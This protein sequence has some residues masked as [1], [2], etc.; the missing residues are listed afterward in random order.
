LDAVYPRNLE[1]FARCFTVL[2]I[3]ADPEYKR[4]PE[5]EQ[6]LAVLQSPA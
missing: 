4:R 5:P 3:D 6:T 1:R 2:G